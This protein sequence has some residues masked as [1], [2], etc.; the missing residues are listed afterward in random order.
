MPCTTTRL[1]ALGFTLLIAVAGCGGDGIVRYPVTG[2]VSVSGQVLKGKTGSVTFKPDAAKGNTSPLEPA[3]LL[4]KD[5]T[6]TLRT[7]NQ[8]GAPAGHYKV[9]VH[10][11]EAGLDRENPGKAIIHRKFSDL[12]STPIVVEVTP[13]AAPKSFDLSLTP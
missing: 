9:L 11:T 2:T 8:P 1:C 13:A 4:E 5:G 10:V 12:K 6:Y 3:G 7:N